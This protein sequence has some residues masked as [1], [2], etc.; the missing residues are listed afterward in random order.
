MKKKILSGTVKRHPDGFGFF[1]PDQKEHPD[2]YIPRN[3]MTGVMTN[4]KVSLSVEP[5]RGGERF[6]GEVI[7]VLHRATKHV[8]GK[9]SIHGKNNAI[10]RDESHAWGQDMKLS[11]LHG[12]QVGQLVAAEILTYPDDEKGFTGKI[13]EVIGS[14]EDPMNDI[15]RIIYSLQIPHEFPEEVEQEASHFGEMPT[16]KDFQG[17]VDLREKKLITIDGATAK[18]CRLCR[19]KLQGIFGLCRNS[20]CQPLCLIEFGY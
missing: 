8:V 13:K 15:K 19:I 6:R 10:L 11:E 5:E 2:V 4:D 17:R 7:R 3:S 20:R 12:A 16:E 1:I 18:D 14:S 9:I